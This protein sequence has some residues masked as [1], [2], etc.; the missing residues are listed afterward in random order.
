MYSH[1]I[2][3]Y[4]FVHVKFHMSA[5]TCSISEIFFLPCWPLRFSSFFLSWFIYSDVLGWVLLNKECKTVVSKRTIKRRLCA[6]GLRRG[7]AG[8]K[9]PPKHL[10]LFPIPRRCMEA[11][12]FTGQSLFGNTLAKK[13]SLLRITVCLPTQFLAYVSHC[14]KALYWCFPQR[15]T[16]STWVYVLLVTGT[17]FSTSDIAAPQ[18]SWSS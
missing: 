3:Q 14:H 16:G 12:H 13:P 2:L 7:V 6:T 8:S 18:C 15:C 11:V 1:V 4:L 17:R 10:I 9:N 5:F